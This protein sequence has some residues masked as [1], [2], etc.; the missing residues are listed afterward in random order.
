MG[1]PRVTR[2]LETAMLFALMLVSSLALPHSSDG[3]QG[4]KPKT[5]WIGV[6][7]DVQDDRDWP[8]RVSS[9]A[10]NSPAARA[11]L[12]PGDRLLSLAGHEL[13]SY[14]AL[15]ELLAQMQ[16]GQN[17]D[18]RLRRVAEVELDQR[19]RG[20]PRLGVHLSQQDG[21]HG[22]AWVIRAVESGWPAERAGLRAGDRLVAVAGSPL[23]SFEDLQ[24]ALAGVEAGESLRCE[25]ERNV[26]LKLGSRPSDQAQATPKEFAS[27]DGFFFHQPEFDAEGRLQ[28][29]TLPEHPAFPEQAQPSQPGAPGRSATPRGSQPG[30]E[31]QLRR[32]LTDLSEELRS[33]RNE[34]RSLRQELEV[35][36]SQRR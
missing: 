17:A 27:P 14:S 3:A 16:P 33:L 29:R 8:L 22:E 5:A 2:D 18:L 25:V 31:G 13:T 15:T 26:D 9:V 34:L 21:E 19:E 10:G 6:N 11:D 36:R 23:G 20:G 24:D 7:L 30:L 12:R 32:E 35:L 4:A 28:L 1:L